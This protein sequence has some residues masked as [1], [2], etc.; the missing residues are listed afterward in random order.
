MTAKRSAFFIS[1]RTGITAEML[2]QSLLTQFAS[3]E[4][5]RIRL[6]FVDTPEKAKAAVQTINEATRSSGMRPIVFSTLVDSDLRA[7]V[8][9]VD[10]MLLDFFEIFIDPIE[11]ELGVESTHTVGRSHG[12]DVRNYTQRIEAVNYT[13]A[14][15]DGA[16]ARGLGQADVILVGVS[17]CGKTPTCLY[18]ALQF[19]VQ[20]A[21]YPLI[22]EDVGQMRMPAALAH[23]R[24]KIWGLTISAERLHQIRSERRPGSRYASLSNCRFEVQASEALMRSEGVRIL[25]STNK[26]IEELSTTILQEAHLAN[27]VY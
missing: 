27:R 3:L 9:T 23:H 7:V 1:D 15:D 8:R 17:R 11:R 4:F 16:T 20:A 13:M 19:G 21:N 10:A 24:Q 2:G 5:E 12:A 14:H 22:P 6:P 18:L 26:S 25:E